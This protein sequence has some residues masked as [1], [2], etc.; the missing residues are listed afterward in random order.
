MPI[1]HDVRWAQNNHAAH[2]ANLFTGVYQRLC[3][4]NLQ[5]TAIGRSLFEWLVLAV[6]DFYVRDAGQGAGIDGECSLP[7]SVQRGKVLS[8]VPAG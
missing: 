6:F 8:L 5:G 7:W 1:E 2:C 4:V 3:R